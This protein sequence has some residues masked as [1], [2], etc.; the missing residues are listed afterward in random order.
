MQ[1]YT[2]GYI[3]I[4]MCHATYTGFQRVRVPTV[5]VEADNVHGSGDGSSGAAGDDGG[6][7]APG[8]NGSSIAATS[9]GQVP[10]HHQRGLGQCPATL[11]TILYHCFASKVGK[12]L[13][14]LLGVLYEIQRSCVTFWFSTWGWVHSALVI[15]PSWLVSCGVTH[16]GS[17]TLHG[18]HMCMSRMADTTAQSPTHHV[19]TCRLLACSNPGR[20]AGSASRSSWSAT[21]GGSSGTASKSVVV[22]GSQ[23]CPP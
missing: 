22:R 8:N 10:A 13:Q 7:A 2:S 3:Y 9:S 12:K 18:W 6:G 4:R 23:T 1:P 15:Q 20:H 16:R 21:A 17:G 11:H 14:L 5:A 19:C